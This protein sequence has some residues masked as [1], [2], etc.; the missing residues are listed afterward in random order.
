MTL[1]NV[2]SA[3]AATGAGGLTFVASVG[4]VEGV[5]TVS[6]YRP[7]AP[8]TWS[9]SSRWLLVAAAGSSGTQVALFDMSVVVPAAN[10]TAGGASWAQK[11]PSSDPINAAAFSADSARAA[12]CAQAGN[13]YEGAASA[14]CSSYS[15]WSFGPD[16]TTWD[17]QN[18]CNGLA[19]SARWVVSAAVH[20]TLLRVQPATPDAQYACLLARA[21][22]VSSIVIDGALGQSNSTELCSA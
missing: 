6:G 20:D 12:V 19:R 21:G 14:A 10:L 9:P 15:T 5:T 8:L 22:T 18:Y 3:A 2:S 16:S 4:S 7:Q 17:A 1:W 13:V 11:M